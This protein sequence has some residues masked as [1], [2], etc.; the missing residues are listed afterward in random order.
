MNRRESVKASDILMRKKP[1][2]QKITIG[3]E[4]GSEK[5]G[6]KFGCIKEEF[7]ATL[8]LKEILEIVKEA[9]GKIE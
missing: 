4:V 7:L 5:G 3:I 2:M 8:T 1:E 6:L 9:I